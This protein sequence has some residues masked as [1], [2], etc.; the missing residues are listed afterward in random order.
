[1]SASSVGRTISATE[2]RYSFFRYTYNS[3]DG[4]SL[5][6]ILF[7][8]T[9]PTASKIKE[10]MIYATSRRFAVRVAETEVGLKVE[11]T[12]EMSDPEELTESSI[13][14]EFKPKVE[15]KKAFERPNRPGRR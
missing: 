5:S 7:V 9:C 10:R 4:S 8:Y 1:V 13:E 14:E 12:L 2:P 15:V 11:K 6:P 3:D